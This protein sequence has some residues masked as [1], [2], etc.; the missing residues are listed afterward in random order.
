MGPRKERFGSDYTSGKLN[1][2]FVL[3]SECRSIYNTARIGFQAYPYEG[4]KKKKKV[5]VS[6]VLLLQ[7]N[8]V[9]WQ[10]A[11]LSVPS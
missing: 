1:S 8:Q 10:L 6:V 7:I 2:C 5:T 9:S 3:F 11:Y 4:K